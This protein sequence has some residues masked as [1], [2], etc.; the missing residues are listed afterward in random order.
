MADTQYSINGVNMGKASLNSLGWAIMRE[1]TNQLTGINRS[2]NKVTVPGYDGYFMA[3]STRT[4]QVMVFNIRTPR[5]NLEALLAVLSYVGYDANFPTMGMI[6]LST[7][8]GK[9]AY[10]DLVSAI[11]ASTDSNDAT[12]NVTV[13]MNIPYGGW[14]DKVTT[15][16]DTT[17]TTNPQTIATIASGLSL[18]IRD[19]DVFIQGNVG[20]MQIT[21][22]AGSWLRTTSSYVYS[23]GYGIFFQGS[24]GR[25]FSATT[26]SPWAP[27]SDISFAVDTMGGGFKMTPQFNPTTPNTRSVSLQVISTNLTSI[28][29]KVRSRGAYA[30][31]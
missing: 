10:Y 7:A 9:A 16:V 30:L 11:P 22:S 26:G 6:E 25:A 2:V 4:E 12:V 28:A 14:R 27:V 13:T 23:A 15:Q 5:G 3:P 24:T 31:K 21:D 8:S 18:P 29:V 17:I 19:M 20:T 1:G